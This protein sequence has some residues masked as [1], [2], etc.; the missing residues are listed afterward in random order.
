MG[1]LC[2]VTAL[3]LLEKYRLLADIRYGCLFL[4]L[5]VPNFKFFHL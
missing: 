1:A 5:K 4:A 3:N 2:F